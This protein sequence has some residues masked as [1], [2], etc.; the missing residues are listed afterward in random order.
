MNVLQ[1]IDELRRRVPEAAPAG[2]RWKGDTRVDSPGGRLQVAAA[3]RIDPAGR[4]REQFWCNGVRLPLPVLLRLACAEADCPHAAQVR[5]QW[6]A[7]Y[8]LRAARRA[9]TAAAAQAQPLMQ[10]Q[11]LRVGGQAFTA[12]PARFPCFT[13]CPHGAHPPLTIHQRGWD[14]FADGQCLGGGVVRARG[15]QRPRLP[16]L[17]AAEAFAF[18]RQLEAGA[19]VAAARE[20]SGGAAGG[21]EE[22]GR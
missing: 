18:A 13:A 4:R 5:A 22:P 8:G 7:R 16:T 10:E 3:A 9:D 21:P 2:T 20:A 12:R 1:L 19:A 14:L 17:Q 11:T 15:L 6:A